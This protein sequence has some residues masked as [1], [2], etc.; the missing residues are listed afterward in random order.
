MI[1]GLSFCSVILYS[2]PRTV[3]YFSTLFRKKSYDRTHLYFRARLYTFIALFLILLGCYIFLV[4]KS[5]ELAIPYDTFS[6][7]LIVII[8][9]AFF[10]IWL[11]LDVYWTIAIKTY[12]DNKHSKEQQAL[13]QADQ[14][15]SM[16][17][18]QFLSPLKLDE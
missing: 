1:V 3:A 5:A 4:V 8:A 17:P 16:D 7:T 2:L 13:D 12:K 6:S 11:G 15:N 9:S 14:R 10:V 18:N